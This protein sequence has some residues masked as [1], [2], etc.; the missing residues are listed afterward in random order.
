M[1]KKNGSNQ[2]V[3][4]LVMKSLAAEFFQSMR[5]A[6]ITHADRRGDITLVPVGTETQ[7]EVEMQVSLIRELIA[8]G[9]DAMVVVPI[10]SQAL[11]EPVAQAIYAGIKVINADVMLDSDLMKQ[12]EIDPPFVGPDHVMA[13]KIA[14]DL[15][16]RQLGP[17]A[18]VVMIEGIPGAINAQQ[19]QQGFVMSAEQNG[20]VL[21]DSRSANWKPNR[22]TGS[23]RS[24]STTIPILKESCAP[25]T[26]WRC[27]LCRFSRSASRIAVSTRWASTTTCRS[28]R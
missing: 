9:V 3:I 2:P 1:A 10:D 14:G 20:L 22:R 28:A 12:Y 6:A 21:L 19:R 16:A 25:T 18:K 7:T 27:G 26:R 24:C 4:G 8:Q 17:A 13:A 15:L 5:S 23:F 11:V